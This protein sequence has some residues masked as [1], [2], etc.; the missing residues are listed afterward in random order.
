MGKLNVLVKDFVKQVGKRDGLPDF[1]V[2]E[3]GGKIFT[4]GSYRLGVHGS[5]ADIDT[6][7]VV[8]QHVSRIDF[9]GLFYETL[10]A[11]PEI[12]EITQVPDAYVPVIKMVF[13]NIPIDLVF[14]RLLMSS[15]PENLDLLDANHLRNLDEKCILSLNGSR[16]TDEILRLVPNVATFHAA[17]K[18]IKVWAKNRGLYSTSMGYLGGVAYA[19]L[20]ARI[21]QLYPNAAPSMVVNRFFKIYLQWEWPQPVLLKQIEDV[22]YLQMKV[23]NPKLYPSD[24]L[25][26]MPI[27]TP[28]F[29]S[30]CS[31]HNV[32]NSTLT[33]LTK[34]MRR[35]SEIMLKIEQKTANWPELFAKTEFFHVNKHFI[36]IIATATSKDLFKIWS[37]YMESRVRH[38]SNKLEYINHVACSPPF[39]QGFEFTCKND[40]EGILRHHCYS[41]AEN[42]TTPVST[43]KND[44]D[45]E[46][47]VFSVAFYIALIIDVKAAGNGPIRL[48][49]HRP[50]SEFKEFVTKWD[51]YEKDMKITIRDLRRDDLPDY[52]F[53][54]G[55]RPLK[56]RKVTRP[57]AENTATKSVAS[58]PEGNASLLSASDPSKR[59]NQSV[60]SGENGSPPLGTPSQMRRE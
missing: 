34:E 49:I 15:I 16:T 58:L 48:D 27:I 35:G 36:Q 11:V 32:S 41:A 60:D 30:M 33:V 56:M 42:K 26:K 50:V 18:C 13:S 55:E 10:Q 4:F 24:R 39:P 2:N 44:E 31:T 7:C 12:S 8:P 52:L 25:H 28:A 9:F 51:K 57:K 22:P 21:C 45:S 40:M 37:G 20:V 5:G 29:P 47:E 59:S 53:E 3:A 38:L 43:E 1:I 23:W 6:L 19:M 46:T 17:L 14:A 54:N